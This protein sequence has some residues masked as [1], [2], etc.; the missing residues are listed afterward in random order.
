MSDEVDLEKKKRELF[1][2]MSP[3]SQQRILKKGYD[4]W[5]PFLAPKEP[6]FYRSQDRD[7]LRDPGETM[8]RFLQEKQLGRPRGEPLP[9]DYVEGVRE[10]CFG[11]IRDPSQRTRG[12]FDFCVWL[13]RQEGAGGGGDDRNG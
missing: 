4:R 11:L 3:R 12:I 7:G 13:F 1:E 9:L 2:S 10:I 8:R 6:P 5:E